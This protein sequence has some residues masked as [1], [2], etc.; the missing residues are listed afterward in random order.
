MT[1]KALS[2]T[3]GCSGNTTQRYTTARFA[4]H[5]AQ[6]PCLL[7]SATE[8]LPLAEQVRRS[9]SA[10]CNHLARRLDPDRPTL[11]S[12]RLSPAFWGKDDQGRPLTGHAHAFFLPADEDVDGR[13]DH[14]TVYAPMGFGPLECRAIDRLRRLKFADEDPLHLVLN[15]LGNPRDFRARSSRNRPCGPRPRRSSLLAIR[16]CAASSVIG[17]QITPRPRPSPGTCFARSCAP[18]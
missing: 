1:G 3:I 15:G 17:P 18:K 14:V 4:V 6:G 9:L 11:I 8:T 12:W 7:P 5:V 2:L 16:S 10:K 13:V